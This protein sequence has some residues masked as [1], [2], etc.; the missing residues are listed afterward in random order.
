[1]ITDIIGQCRICNQKHFLHVS[2]TSEHKEENLKISVYNTICNSCMAKVGFLPLKQ[3]IS[4]ISKK[5]N[6]L[7]FPEKRK[8]ILVD[9]STNTETNI[10]D[11]NQK[12]TLANVSKK[13]ENNKK[14]P[15]IN[16]YCVG[17]T[18]R[19][20]NC[21]FCKKEFTHTGDLNKHRR[22][23][24]GEKPYDCSICKRK[25]SHASNLVRHQRIHSGEKPFSCPL[26]CGRNFTRKDKL[27][28]HV[29]KYHSSTKIKH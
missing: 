12:S 25:F 21:E 1:M 9:A 3:L 4:N 18:E 26:K 19:S 2:E 8:I 5:N 13:E 20:L 11:E 7:I 15:T 14:L 17:K 24:T 6:F 10:D 28:E 23:H 22:K 16:N 29:S 27:S